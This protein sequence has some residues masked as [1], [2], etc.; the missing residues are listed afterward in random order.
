VVK[1]AG[2]LATG[3]NP[4][5]VPYVSAAGTLNEDVATSFG[6]YVDATNHRFGIGVA[7]PAVILDVTNLGTTGSARIGRNSGQYVE[8]MSTSS[9]NLIQTDTAGAKNLTIQNL[10][11]GNGIIIN[12]GTSSGSVS[13]SAG[14]TGAITLTPGTGA[15]Q[16]LGTLAVGLLNNSLGTLTASILDRTA[17][18]GA[19]NVYIGSDNN[20]HVSATTTRFNLSRGSSDAGTTNTFVTD[21]SQSFSVVAAGLTFKAGSNART[22]TGTLVG[23]TL[24]VA[25]TSITA[26]SQV[27]VQDTGG[28]VIANIGSIYVAS[29]TATTGF[30]VTSSNALDT[31]TFRY[32]IYETN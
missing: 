20:G 24:A 28:G 22:G 8:I 27:F 29:Q 31:S 9:S 6:P 19:T 17:S 16:V 23:G 1:G 5:P 26:N 21:A 14:T 11:T 2:N 18:T 13:I 15:V 25:N 3:G 7:A 10:N 4:G 12:A 32:W 30:T